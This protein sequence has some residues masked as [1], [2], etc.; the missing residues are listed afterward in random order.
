[1]TSQSLVTINIEPCLLPH[2]FHSTNTN[3]STVQVQEIAAPEYF[4]KNLYN[5]IMDTNHRSVYSLFLN[6]EPDKVSITASL[7]QWLDAVCC[8]FRLCIM[9]HIGRLEGGSP[10]L[11]HHSPALHSC[12][13]TAMMSLPQG[14]SSLYKYI[15]VFLWRKNFFYF[16]NNFLNNSQ[17]MSH[18]GLVWGITWGDLV[19]A[20]HGWRMFPFCLAQCPGWL[21]PCKNMLLFFLRFL[22]NT[23]PLLLWKDEIGQ[24]GRNNIPV[25]IQNGVKQNRSLDVLASSHCG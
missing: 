3:L 22:I 4:N 9:C 21:N 1:M 12:T 20:K 7:L 25:E 13:G 16:L 19:T 11:L 17:T 14:A 15:P 24:A 18:Y 10:W 5:N 8:P 6:I 2:F 23:W